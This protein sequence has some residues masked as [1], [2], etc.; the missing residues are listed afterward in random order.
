MPWLYLEC[1][2][3]GRRVVARFVDIDNVLAGPQTSHVA[4]DP[5][6]RYLNLIVYHTYP[7]SLL[8]RVEPC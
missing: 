4:I 8:Y 5:L 3:G 6:A 2:D 1:P 7:L